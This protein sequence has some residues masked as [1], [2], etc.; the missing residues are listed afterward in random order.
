MRCTWGRSCS[1][2]PRSRGSRRPTRAGARTVSAERIGCDEGCRRADLSAIRRSFHSRSP[3]MNRRQPAPHRRPGR[4]ALRLARCLRRRPPP[5]RRARPLGRARAR[6]SPRPDEGAVGVVGR[7]A[8]VAARP[9]RLLFLPRSGPAA[10]LRRA[11]VP[12]LRQA[13]ERPRLEVLPLAQPSPWAALP[14]WAL[15][16]LGEPPPPLPVHHNR[17]ARSW[18]RPESAS[19]GPHAS[20]T[21]RS[22]RAWRRPCRTSG[23]RA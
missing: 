13:W 22:T 16:V 7:S 8:T 18:L 20:V 2:A 21:Q 23:K 14:R 1:P 17:A 12:P 4:P 15:E 6:P 9:R 3:R 5:P 10:L 11:T 19:S